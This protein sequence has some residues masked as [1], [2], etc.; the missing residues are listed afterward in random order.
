MPRWRYPTKTRRLEGGGWCCR[1]KNV[2]GKWKSPRDDKQGRN[3]TGRGFVPEQNPTNAIRHFLPDTQ[4]QVVSGGGMGVVQFQLQPRKKRAVEGAKSPK[5]SNPQ[6]DVNRAVCTKH[7]K[8]NGCNNEPDAVRSIH[9]TIWPVRTKASRT[10]WDFRNARFTG[11]LRPRTLAFPLYH[12]HRCGDA[13]RAGG[14]AVGVFYSTA[15]A[16]QLSL[17]GRIVP[18]STPLDEPAKT[19]AQ[20][21]RQCTNSEMVHYTTIHNAKKN[22][23]PFRVVCR[24]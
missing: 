3:G 1:A 4:S 11:I 14:W 17:L 5:Q 24:T 6:R 21:V 10:Y 7:T 12:M 2:D 16:H 8:W 13:S 23:L 15:A 22:H 20:S 19:F 18:A 9:D